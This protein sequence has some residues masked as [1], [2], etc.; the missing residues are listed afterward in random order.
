M[1]DGIPAGLTATEGRRFAFPVGG[2]FLVLGGVAWWR[3]HGELAIALAALAVL[4]GALGL[5]FPTRLG[6][7]SRAWM[8]LAV[9]IS[10]VTTPIFMGVIFFGVIAP[11]GLLLRVLGKGPLAS[12]RDATSLWHRREVGARRSNLS[13]QF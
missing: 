10:K 7:V 8:G 3:G 6:P 5:L 4:L 1:A 11:I 9:A 2:A 13:R 12:R